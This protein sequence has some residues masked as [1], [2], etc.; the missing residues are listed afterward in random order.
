MDSV[1]MG[2]KDILLDR[3]FSGVAWMISYCYEHGSSYPE[4]PAAFV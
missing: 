2:A 1:R 3:L 4:L